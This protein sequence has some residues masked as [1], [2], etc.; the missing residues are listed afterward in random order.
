MRNRDMDV[1][2]MVIEQIHLAFSDIPTP[3][4]TGIHKM[5]FTTSLA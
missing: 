3:P 4:A 2:E 1:W 5:S